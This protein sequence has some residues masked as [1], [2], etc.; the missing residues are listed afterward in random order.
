MNWWNE[1]TQL[2][3]FFASV[4]IPATLIMLIQFILQ[5]L[6]IANEQDGVDVDGADFDGVDGADLDG[7]DG[8]DFDGVDGVDF[9][10]VDGADFDASMDLPDDYQTDISQLDGT[11]KDSSFD[12]DGADVDEGHNGLRLFTLRSIIAFFAVGGWMGVAAVEWNLPSILAVILA[13]VAG[14]L[15]MYFVAWTIFTFL[16]MQQSGS[17]R[18]ENAVGKEGV[19]YLTIPVGGRGK[20][21]VIVQD[22]LCELSAQTN[23]ERDIKTGEKI[24]VVDFNP[25]GVLI[26]E[27]RSLSKKNEIK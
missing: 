23:S 8:A 7:I 26:V 2:Q 12:H 22:R 10:A 16:K 18:Y 9:D 6:G 15:A 3:K 19:V 14:T 20:V 5:L 4:A 21:S 27:P 25:D 13:A 1:F 17:M 11:F 24:V